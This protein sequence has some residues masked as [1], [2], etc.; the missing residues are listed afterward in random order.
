MA[1]RALQL[2]RHQP[3]GSGLERSAVQ[4]LGLPERAPSPFPQDSIQACPMLFYE[5][6]SRNLNYYRDNHTRTES[7]TH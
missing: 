2:V 5:A 1:E 6:L 4:A 7:I 3:M